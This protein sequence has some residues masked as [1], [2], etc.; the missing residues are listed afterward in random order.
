MTKEKIVW[1]KYNTL[2]TRTVRLPTY[3]YVRKHIFQRGGFQLEQASISLADTFPD[4]SVAQK[5]WLRGREHFWTPC[6]SVWAC[7]RKDWMAT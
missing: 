5:R 7:L 6:R 3:C 1:Q 2:H 4:L